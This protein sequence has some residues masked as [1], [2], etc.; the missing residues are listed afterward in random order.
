MITLGPHAAPSSVLAAKHE[1]AMTVTCGV[2]GYRRC[3]HEHKLTGTAVF[4]QS[5]GVLQCND[6]G[7][8][9]AIKKPL[10]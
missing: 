1:L 3:F 9:Q 8:Y 10:N 6:C 7:G 5:L 4:F 2:S